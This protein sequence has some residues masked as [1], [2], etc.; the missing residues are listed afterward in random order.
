MDMDRA[1]QIFDELLLFQWAPTLGGECYQMVVAL[2]LIFGR[3]FEFQWAPTLGG[4]CYSYAQRKA[5]G[6][7]YGRFQWAPTL[8]G[9]CYRRNRVAN[10]VN[11]FQF[12]WAPTLGGECYSNGVRQEA[13]HGLSVSMGTHPWG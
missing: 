8:G 2:E 11:R 12:Q 13:A 10:P 7:T 1:I 4:E 6:R 9:E 5:L 3:K